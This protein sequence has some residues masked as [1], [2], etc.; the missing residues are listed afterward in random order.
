VSTAGRVPETWEL[1]GD[2]ARETLTR[3][4][5]GRLLRDGFMRLRYADGFS[6]ARS[7]AFATSLVLVQGLIAFV[8]FASVVS[9]GS[10]ARS[11]VRVI[12]SAVPGPANR[13]LTDAVTQAYVA[14]ATSRWL[15]L[16]LG[17]VGALITGATLFGQLERGL[18]R[19]YGVEQD[20]PA[21][22]KYGLAFLLFVTA[23]AG[24]AVAFVVFAFGRNVG[25][26][27]GS[28]ARTI[29]DV[30]RWP[31]AL[32]LVGAAMAL[33]FRWSPRRRQ[34][35]WSWLAYGSALSV[36][37]WSA[38]TLAL[39]VMFR[40][41][42]SFGETYGPLAGIVAL[43]IWTLLSAISILYGAAVAAQLEAVRA[44]EP[45]VQD[46]QKVDDHPAATDAGA[47]VTTY[48]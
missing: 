47:L 8:G 22:R 6:H 33:L 5:V 11:V 2:D 48:S 27:F 1:G 13:V 18:N 21:L 14:G 46:P 30:A 29:W 12:R 4:G 20:R 17:T 32:A 15:P 40:A 38:S 41:S 9:D 19:I 28:D 43:Q 26:E 36:V 34:P 44:G 37:L 10:I 35:A 7:M 39:G 24:G 25:Q 16:V 45:E 23:G 3:I 31:L 42:T